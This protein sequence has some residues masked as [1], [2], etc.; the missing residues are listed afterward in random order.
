MRA[1]ALIALAMIGLGCAPADRVPSPV[2][3]DSTG[4]IEPPSAGR[5]VR[6]SRVH[7]GD[8]LTILLDGKEERVRLIGINAPEIDECWGEEARDALAEIAGI[9]VRVEF[10]IEERDGYGRLLAYVWHEDVLVNAD[11]VARGAALGVRT[12]DETTHLEFIN[13]RE[14]TAKSQGVGM[15]SADA[16]GEP[17]PSGL[18]ISHV[19]ANPPGP[20]QDD[21]RSESITIANRSPAPIPIG[22][23]VLRDSSTVHRYR[24]PVDTVI[25]P[26]A[27]IRVVTGC[28][29]DTETTL[30]WCAD[31]PVWNNDGDDVLLLTRLGTIVDHREYGG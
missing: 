31:G 8:S 26:G 11:L 18:E 25:E 3:I 9:E 12:G 27:E 10:G 20:D 19:A 14:E 2:G 23:F 22:G 6:V 5:E 7:D 16:C 4:P 15:W 13:S 17:P 29:A 24:F 30:H 1:I 21:L 28:G